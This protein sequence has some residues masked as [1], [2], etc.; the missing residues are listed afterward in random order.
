MFFIYSNLSETACYFFET[1]QH[2]LS[3]TASVKYWHHILLYA[4]FRGIVILS[5]NIGAGS[6]LTKIGKVFKVLI[7]D[8]DLDTVEQL[9]QVLVQMDYHIL[10]ATTQKQARALISSQSID[11]LVTDLDSVDI[12][13]MDLAEKTLGAFPRTIV[14]GMTW[15]RNVEVA[16]A[17][18]KMGGLDYLAKPL[19]EKTIYYA[20]NVALENWRNKFQHQQ[21]D[22]RIRE[23]KSKFM[24]LKAEL[25]VIDEIPERVMNVIVELNKDLDVEK[26]YEIECKLKIG[27][28]GSIYKA[29]D[30]QLHRHVAFKRLDPLKV[31]QNENNCEL[32]WEAM[33]LTSIQHPNILTVYDFGI[34][35]HGPYV[36]TEFIEGETIN[37]VVRRETYAKGPFI[38]A[39]NQTLEGLIAAHAVGLNHRDLKPQN[40]MVSHMASQALRYTILDFGLAELVNTPTSERLEKRDFIYGT[41]CYVSPEQ[42][43]QKTLDARSDLYQLGCVY[44]YML[45]GANA[46]NGRTAEEIIASHLNH[47]VVPLYKLRMDMPRSI[48]DWVMSLIN[49]KPADRPATAAVALQTFQQAVMMQPAESIP[50]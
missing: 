27:G 44:Y 28:H 1:W 45:S 25:C 15:E 43:L 34:D 42:L 10:V 35:E 16:L 32:W 14:I 33:S 38:Q 12:D 17:F 9:E 37:A 47:W 50:E 20:L 7:V 24:R 40:I 23:L 31:L 41:I 49:R 18:M 21:G 46:F 39:V 3:P 48:C 36:I 26:R 8:K 30:K 6:M 11:I 13:G 4:L 2:A 19:E 29:W 22:H 5:V